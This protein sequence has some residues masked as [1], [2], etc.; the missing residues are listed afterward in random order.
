MARVG[1]IHDK[2]GHQWILMKAVAQRQC[3]IEDTDADVMNL[4]RE[5]SHRIL[6]NPRALVL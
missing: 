3:A 5:R 1:V 4:F 2:F 6:V